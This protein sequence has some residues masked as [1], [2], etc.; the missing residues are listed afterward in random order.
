[1][2]VNQDLLKIQTRIS[3]SFLRAYYPIDYRSNQNILNNVD[4]LLD[5]QVRGL[6]TLANTTSQI[7]VRIS[8]TLQGVSQEIEGLYAEID[9][10]ENT[11]KSGDDI[12][13]ARLSSLESMSANIF[14]FLPDLILLPGGD[15]KKKKKPKKKPKGK[16]GGGPPPVSDTDDKKKPKG[17]TDEKKSNGKEKFKLPRGLGVIAFAWAAWELIDELQALDTNMKKSEYRREVSRILGKFIT[18]FG[19]AWAGAIVGAFVGSAFFGVGAIVGFIAGLVGGFVADYYFGETADQLV[20]NVVDY[21]FT[22]ED[23]EEQ[24]SPDASLG[25]DAS[26][27]NMEAPAPAPSLEPMSAPMMAAAAASVPLAPPIEGPLPPPAPMEQTVDSPVSWP[28]PL[29]PIIM[30]FFAPSGQAAGPSPDQIVADAERRA[31]LYVPQSAEEQNA[32]MMQ[33]AGLS[34][35]PDLDPS[36]AGGMSDTTGSLRTS[37]DL[38]G[39]ISVQPGEGIGTGTVQVIEA[40]GPGRPGRPVQRIRDI[41][42]RAAEKAGMSQ[43]TFTSGVGDYI[44]EKRR[45]A[46]QKTTKH[47]EGIALDVD[48]FANQEQRIAFMQAAR[49]LGAG[50]IGAYKDGSVHIDLGPSRE[51]DLAVGVAGL[52]E[53]GKVSKPTL[54]LIGEAG[55]PEYVVPQSKA[56]KF[57]HEMIAARPHTRTKKHT[58]VVV[59]P[60][61]T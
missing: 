52:A 44:D 58:H 30:D 5:R 22:G 29:P 2:A 6:R 14:D 21:L 9:R 25:G 53:G 37:Q 60:I 20:D 48:G 56:I 61:L 16:T 39:G 27:V 36:R 3:N 50:G 8:R 54:A 57:A 13:G 23:D 4:K 11:V 38:G 12:L 28:L 42:V 19:I 55:E 46:G 32:Y 47:S 33:G 59:V 43:I 31:Q 45:A 35:R 40:Y 7:T 51:W 1:M 15:R 34:G 24:T 26:I 49:Q 10:L 18:S 41:A 17:D